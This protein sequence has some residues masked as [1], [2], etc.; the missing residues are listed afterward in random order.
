VLDPVPPSRVL[1][2]LAEFEVGLVFDRPQ[3][4]NIELSMPNKVFEYLMAGLAVVA[5]RLESLGPL[6]DEERVGLTFEPGRPD[7]LI[8]TLERLA[9]DRELLA[10]LRRR[11][12]T[13]ALDR[14]NAEAAAGTL[15]AAWEDTDAG[16]R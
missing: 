9:G 5:P 3:S 14:L 6:L 13:L 7:S 2:A 16:V 15:A 4:R 11:A 10:E 12:R 8:R 1:D